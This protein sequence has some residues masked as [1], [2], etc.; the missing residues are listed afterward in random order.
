MHL[1]LFNIGMGVLH[2]CVHVEKCSLQD[3]V[4]S[5]PLYTCAGKVTLSFCNKRVYSIVCM[6]STALTF[7][8]YDIIA[9]LLEPYNEVRSMLASSL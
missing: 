1:K 2:V 8:S 9:V 4:Q 7:A 3:H 6:P 5:H